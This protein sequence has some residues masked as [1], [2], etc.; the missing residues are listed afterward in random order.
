MVAAMREDVATGAARVG[1]PAVTTTAVAAADLRAIELGRQLS[2]SHVDAAAS[3]R[4]YAR[5]ALWLSRA[6]FSLDVLIAIGT[7]SSI[8]AWAIWETAAGSLVWTWILG[9]VAV[10]NIVKPMLGLGGRMRKAENLATRWHKVEVLLR[11][12]VLNVRAEGG[13]TPQREAELADV[14]AQEDALSGEESPAVVTWYFKRICKEV[15]EEFPPEFHW[16]R[17]E[18]K[19]LDELARTD[20]DEQRDGGDADGKEEADGEA[21]QAGG[22]EEAQGNGQDRNEASQEGEPEEEE[23]EGSGEEDRQEAGATG[24]AE[25]DQQEA[26][27]AQEGSAPPRR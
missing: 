10:A 18:R 12:L 24:T 27:R 13:L 20:G 6:S 21:R 19:T 22:D 1:A 26:P 11:R 15:K 17:Y 16:P 2:K 14:T 25:E 4:Y 8:A 23:Q 7:G 5:L 9:S 3:A